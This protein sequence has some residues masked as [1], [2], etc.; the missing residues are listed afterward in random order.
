D[1]LQMPAVHRAPAPEAG[2]RPRCGAGGGPVRCR[3]TPATGAGTVCRARPPA[4]SEHRDVH[5]VEVVLGDASAI[6]HVPPALVGAA[7][8]PDLLAVDD[9]HDAQPLGVVLGPVGDLLAVRDL[10][11]RR[12]LAV[13]VDHEVAGPPLGVL[14]D[15]EAA[16]RAVAAHPAVLL[17]LAEL[18]GDH[19]ADR[20]STR[21]NSS[22]VK[23]SYAVF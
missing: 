14:A 9:V 7:D 5:V 4:P 3:I 19:L 16:V 23:I 20:K 13:L 1:S 15:H 10:V 17:V 21:L 6:G 22:H 2:S 12:H 18:L 8:V 11:L